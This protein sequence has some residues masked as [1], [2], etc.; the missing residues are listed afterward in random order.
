MPDRS[1]LRSLSLCL[2]WIVAAAVSAQAQ[3]GGRGD[4]A[5]AGDDRVPR[6]RVGLGLAP[7][8]FELDEAGAASRRD[9]TDTA[10]A[11]LELDG[12]SRRG[13]GGGFRFEGM[14]SDDDLFAG[15]GTRVEATGRSFYGHFTWQLRER[16]FGMRTRFGAMLDRLDVAN[17]PGSGSAFEVDYT[18]IGPYFE[19]EPE[20][21]VYRRGPL[22]VSAFARFGIGGGITLIERTG[23][24]REW[25]S[26]T[27]MIGFETGARLRYLHLELQS[28]YLGRWRSMDRSGFE[29][30]SAIDSYDSTFHGLFFGFGV[31]F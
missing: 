2:V 16:S 25:D 21:V 20:L 28:S 8:R 7:G 10:F 4:G 30:G 15:T 17:E 19:M 3:D 26:T 11:R 13:F 18:T 29:G 22:S 23:D 5:R 27:G 24:G 9:R 14:R 1:P 12:V 6:F 31:A